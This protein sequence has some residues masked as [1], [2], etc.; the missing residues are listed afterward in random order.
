V[1]WYDA[2]SNRVATSTSSFVPTNQVAGTY[3]FFASEVNAFGCESTNRTAIDLTL[4]DCPDTLSISLIG[5][6]AVVQWYGNY[7]LQSATNLV[8]ADW[9]DL[10]QGAGGVT[11]SFT[12]SITLPPSN[13]FFRLFGTGN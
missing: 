3:H 9:V 12:N 4:E 2:A 5:T 11:N 8:P 1:N 7:I 10:V 13:N 6:N